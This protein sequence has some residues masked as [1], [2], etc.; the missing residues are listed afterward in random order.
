MSAQRKSIEDYLHQVQQGIESV[1]EPN[2]LRR[3][4]S[5]VMQ[6]TSAL[7]AVSNPDD[8]HSFIVKE[9]FAPAQKNETQLQFKR[10]SGNAG[11]K[12]E[13]KTLRYYTLCGFHISYLLV[14]YC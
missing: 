10:T 14:R 4:L 9:R 6:A 1:Q 2:I 12:K 5:L 3:V 8:V 7:K 13:N 11:R